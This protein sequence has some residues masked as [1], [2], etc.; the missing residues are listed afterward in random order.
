MMESDGNKDVTSMGSKQQGDLWV[1]EDP[2]KEM[3]ETEKKY[4]N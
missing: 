2:T 1:R 3:F 4:R